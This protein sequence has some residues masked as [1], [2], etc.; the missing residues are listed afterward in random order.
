MRILFPALFLA[1]SLPRAVS[2]APLLDPAASYVVGKQKKAPGPA[3]KAVENAASEMKMDFQSFDPNDPS[4]KPLLSNQTEQRMRIR[5]LPAEPKKE[6]VPAVPER[7]E[8]TFE[9][10]ATT[11]TVAVAGL[12]QPFVTRSDLGAF[13]GSKPILITG[14]GSSRK[15]EGLAELRAKA[16]QDVKDPIARSTLLGLLNEE[17]L[18][19]TGESSG[20]GASCLSA[21]EKK[22]PGDKWAFSREEQG[23]KLEYDC[24]F[25]GWA[26]AK[27]KALAVIKL[28]NRKSRQR[29]QQPNGVPGMAETEG[30]G[31]MIVEPVSGESLVKMDTSIT[32]EPLEEEINRLRATGRPVPRNK[33]LLKH[34]NHLYPL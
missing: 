23:V 21:F 18:L 8:L 17:V 14:D 19:R 15:V 9:K 29:R 25:E 6:N 28:V 2:A 11:S 31:V 12:P 7:L 34:W 16:M 22:A 27:G 10:L 24:E 5:K 26:E 20:T 30:S 13:L 32:V 33:S 4:G 3:V 1:L